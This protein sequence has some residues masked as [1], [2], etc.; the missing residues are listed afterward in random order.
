MVS[1]SSMSDGPDFQEPP[2][3]DAPEQFDGFWT[4]DEEQLRDLDKRSGRTPRPPA[5]IGQKYVISRDDDGVYFAENISAEDVWS[6][7]SGASTPPKRPF[8]APRGGG[9]QPDTG[10]GYYFS[11]NG[12]DII[13]R[14]W[15]L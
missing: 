5:N 7:R 9:N 14:N 6:L 3:D 11:T 2:I 12:N 15:K 4:P 10:E 1:S 13:E 8:F